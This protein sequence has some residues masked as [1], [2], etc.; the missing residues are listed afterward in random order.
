MSDPRTHTN[1]PV[2]DSD[3]AFEPMRRDLRAM[4]KIDAPPGFE[5]QLKQKLAAASVPRLKWWQRMPALNLGFLRVPA[6]AYGPL[7]GAAVIIFSVYV[8]E[9]REVLPPP[10]APSA[11]TQEVQQEPQSPE[12][13]RPQSDPLSP[14]SE[15]ER[16]QREQ[17]AARRRAEKS[18]T[19]VQ[20]K[21]APAADRRAVQPDKRVDPKA[22][23]LLDLPVLRGVT[24][25]EATID[26]TKKD[27][28]RTPRVP[29]TLRSPQQRTDKN[30]A[31]RK[32]RDN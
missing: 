27:S 4:P 3:A 23:E 10:P 11:P 24:D 19:P 14:A 8:L 22:D 13:P 12:P 21:S 32:P 15:I 26:T 17:E 31:T 5:Y 25:E 20:Q 6:F 29:P 7:A 9:T 18:Q 2:A 30:P 16:K 28:L 1:D